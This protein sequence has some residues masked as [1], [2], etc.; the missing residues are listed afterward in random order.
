MGEPFLTGESKL[1]DLWF[2]LTGQLLESAW[3]GFLSG[4]Y[5]KPYSVFQC[6]TQTTL[7]AM[8]QIT[9]HV[10]QTQK[11]VFF[12]HLARILRELQSL[13]SDIR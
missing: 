4:L 13:V 9:D 2:D 1:S 12:L 8:R 7:E 3:K 11:E 5:N 10:E 6:S